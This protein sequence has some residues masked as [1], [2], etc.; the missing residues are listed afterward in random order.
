DFCV[1]MQK[2]RNEAVAAHEQ[3]A[4]ILNRINDGFIA[5]DKNWICTYVNSAFFKLLN[6]KKKEKIVGKHV[7]AEFP[8]IVGTAFYNLSLEVLNTQRPACLENYFEPWNRWF[9]SRIYPSPSGL[10]IYVT[11]TTEKRHT[12]EKL[13][14]KQYQLS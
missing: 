5:V 14:H 4:D 2:N 7:W 13:K 10:T 8:E 1:K 11:D 9:L 6:R 12:E 3:I